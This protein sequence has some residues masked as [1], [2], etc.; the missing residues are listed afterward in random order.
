MKKRK[1]VTDQQM[2]Q[3]AVREVFNKVKANIDF[4]CVDSTEVC[5]AVTS[6]MTAE[7][8]T[9]ISANIAI[10]MASSGRKTL[11]LD[12]DMRKPNVHK[13]F[14]MVNQR[15]LTDVLVHPVDWRQYVVETGIA[16]L[17]LMTVGR[18]PP[19]PSMLLGSQRFKTLIEEAKKEYDYIIID[20]PPVLPFPD[21]LVLSPITDG[22]L[23][24]VRHAL[25]KSDVLRQAYDELK[26]ANA[27]LIGAVI[28]DV[29]MK[30]S[31]YYGYDYT[32]GYRDD[33]PACNRRRRKK[34]GRTGRGAHA[35]KR[36]R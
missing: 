3:K 22:V 7:G 29:S 34:S 12:A 20:T 16:G 4:T 33:T 6:A 14:K 10:A 31:A 19:N 9:V 8:K 25:T 30:H 18:R 27:K 15:G 35:K 5:I 13:A 26:L 28:N 32:Y 17:S 11:L 24:I 2:N 36:R 21:T 1:T 23:I